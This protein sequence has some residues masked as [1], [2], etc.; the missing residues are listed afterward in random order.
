MSAGLWQAESM[1]YQLCLVGQLLANR[2][3][4]FDGLCTSFQGMINP[5]KGMEIHQLDGGR[6]L[7]RFN[8][9]IDWD[10]ALK[11]CPWTFEENILILCCICKEN[12]MGVNLEWCEFFVHVH[13]ISLS[14]MTLGVAL[15]I[16]NK[17]RRFHDMEMDESGF[18]RD[19]YCGFG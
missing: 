7:L 12:P 13:G 15:M 6:F 1:H 10:R 2:N 18:L 5:V 19:P 8:H 14:M 9:I 17:L 4:R 3:M 16:G 11:G